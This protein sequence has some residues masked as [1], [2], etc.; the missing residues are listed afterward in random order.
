[1]TASTCPRSL[2]LIR[3]A[4]PVAVVHRDHA[5]AGQPGVVALAG[6]AD[7]VGAGV[8]RQLRGEGAHAAGCPGDH[9]RVTPPAYRPNRGIGGGSSDEQRARHFPRHAGRAGHQIAGVGHDELGVAASGI[10]PAEDLVTH[11]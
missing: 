3:S 6:Q 5:M 8:D 10:D 2:R 11:C 4:D 7:H 1:M 9:D